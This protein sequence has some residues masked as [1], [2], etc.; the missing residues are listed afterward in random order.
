LNSA[1]DSSGSKADLAKIPD[2]RALRRLL[3]LPAAV[4]G[5]V[6]LRLIEGGLIALPAP[7]G[8]VVSALMGW[9]SEAFSPST[10]SLFSGEVA[11]PSHE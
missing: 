7:V 10:S 3:L 8:P 5:P 4:R 11:A 9:E 1:G 2:L 6:A